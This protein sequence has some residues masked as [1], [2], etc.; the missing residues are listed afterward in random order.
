[1]VVMVVHETPPSLERSIRYPVIEE[2]PVVAG[3]AQVRATVASDG[4]ATT[5]RGTDGMVNGVA[6]AEVDHAPT[7]TAFTAATR[8]E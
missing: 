8:N 2:P 7:P 6:V 5:E 1:M 4:V 3:A